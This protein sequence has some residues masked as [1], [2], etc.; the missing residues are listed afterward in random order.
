[1]CT[2]FYSTKQRKLKELTKQH[3]EQHFREFFLGVLKMSQTIWNIH[4][5]HWMCTR[6]YVI[7]QRKLKQLMSSNYWRK[8][9]ANGR[10]NSCTHFILVWRVS[11]NIT[12]FCITMRGMSTNGQFKSYLQIETKM[13]IFLT[14]RIHLINA[15]IKH[16]LQL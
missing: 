16:N 7:Q 2:R 9:N 8:W 12:L 15:L 6:C 13:T 14:R 4:T 10:A 11:Q 3:M 5:S 1:M